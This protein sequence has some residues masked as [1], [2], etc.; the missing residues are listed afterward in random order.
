MVEAAK[1]SV[2][3]LDNSFTAQRS[4][5][6]LFEI[7]KH[8]GLNGFERVF[9]GFHGTLLAGVKRGTTRALGGLKL[10]RMTEAT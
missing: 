7:F 10:L 3:P 4:A 1:Y 6:H 2:F 5:S 9:F 8:H